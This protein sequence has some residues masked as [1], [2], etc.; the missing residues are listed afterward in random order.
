MCW[1]WYHFEDCLC[2]LL[3]LCFKCTVYPFLVPASWYVINM[4][5]NMHNHLKPDKW[6]FCCCSDCLHVKSVHHLQALSFLGL[7]VTDEKG[8]KLRQS[9]TTDPQ[10]TVAYGGESLIN[11]HA[12]V[13]TDS[14]F[15]LPQL[16]VTDPCWNAVKS[17]LHCDGCMSL[18]GCGT[19]A[20]CHVEP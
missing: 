6:R 2:C 13:Q 15:E 10:G 3:F 17:L 1:L 4:L 16:Q 19:C 5:A 20:R 18:I 14:C 11:T 12:H 7:D 9:L 8:K